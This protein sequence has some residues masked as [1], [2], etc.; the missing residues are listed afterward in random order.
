MP[1]KAIL[2]V[3][4]LF[5]LCMVVW[6]RHCAR[7]E[8]KQAQAAEHD[9]I[10]ANNDQVLFAVVVK[11]GDDVFVLNEGTK[12]LVFEFSRTK[13][14][15]VKSYQIYDSLLIEAKFLAEKEKTK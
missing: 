14:A 15:D 13:P 6:I 7:A 2:V 8:K 10:L 5:M 9:R 12:Q 11:K 4:A 3:V 1:K